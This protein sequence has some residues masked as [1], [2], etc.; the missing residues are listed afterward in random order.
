MRRIDFEAA[1]GLPS[2]AKLAAAAP[3]PTPGTAL[4]EVELTWI[5]GR[6]EQWIR[7]GRVA[8]ERILNSILIQRRRGGNFPH[9]LLGHFR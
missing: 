2:V 7:F 8:A 5:E 1:L 3:S 4:T 9:A 6:H